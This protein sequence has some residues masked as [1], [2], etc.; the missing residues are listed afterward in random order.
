M[1]RSSSDYYNKVL[2]SEIVGK[3]V[4]E[5]GC[6]VGANFPIVS[7]KAKEYCKEYHQKKKA[8]ALNKE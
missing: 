1:N 8:E 5:F 4:L 2:Q 7:E 6:G 3:S